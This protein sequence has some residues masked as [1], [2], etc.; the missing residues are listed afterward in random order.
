VTVAVLEGL[1]LIFLDLVSWDC[2][3]VA[4]VGC[5]GFALKL[6]VVGIRAF[7]DA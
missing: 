1:G 5:G 6:L 3:V 2:V 4:S 7:G